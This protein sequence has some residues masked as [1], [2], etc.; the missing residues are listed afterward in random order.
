MDVLFLEKALLGLCAAAVLAVAIAKL[1][2]KRFRLPPGP[3]GAPIVGNWFQVGDAMNH[4]DLMGMAKR[5]GEVFL[6]RMGVRNLVVVS[7]PELAKEV[8]HTQGVEFGSRSRNLVFDIF[9]GKG[10]VTKFSYPIYRYF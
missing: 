4:R 5:F 2:G 6:L 3:S 1:T 10:Q 8:L 7:S 9:T